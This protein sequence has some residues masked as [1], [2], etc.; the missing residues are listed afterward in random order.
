VIVISD[1][2]I[3]FLGVSVDNIHM[4]IRENRIIRFPVARVGKFLGPMSNQR[5]EKQR[6]DKKELPHK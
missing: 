5:P 2:N 6:R 3:F 4:E 1:I